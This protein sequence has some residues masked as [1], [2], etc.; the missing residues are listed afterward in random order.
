MYN[1]VQQL[2]DESGRFIP[3]NKKHL[4]AHAKSIRTTSVAG[5]RI[6]EIKDNWDWCQFTGLLKYWSRF[7]Y[8]KVGGT[9]WNERSVHTASQQQVR[10]KVYRGSSL[11]W[12]KFEPY[13]NGAFDNF[14]QNKGYQ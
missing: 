9:K 4:M 3:F 10:Q 13:L 6:K 7:K 12:N 5:N 11:Q 1:L 14:E 8:R 2:V